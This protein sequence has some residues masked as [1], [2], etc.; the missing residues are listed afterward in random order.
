MQGWIINSLRN[1]GASHGSSGSHPGW[2]VHMT[3][4]EYLGTPKDKNGYA[5]HN[6]LKEVPVYPISV[7]GTKDKMHSSLS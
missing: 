7:E 5:K 2:M 6:R 3:T 4:G 1:I